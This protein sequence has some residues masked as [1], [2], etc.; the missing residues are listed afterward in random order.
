M[1][2]YEFTTSPYL[3]ILWQIRCIYLQFQLLWNSWF[4]RSI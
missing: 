2:F 1:S 3:R 4:I